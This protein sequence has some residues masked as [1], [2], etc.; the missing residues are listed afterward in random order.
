MPGLRG[1]TCDARQDQ[2]IPNCHYHISGTARLAKAL[3]H[4]A[5]AVGG[6]Q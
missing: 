6:V 4:I 3:T 2:K 1:I 5:G